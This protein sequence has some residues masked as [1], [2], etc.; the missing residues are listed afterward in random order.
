MGRRALAIRAR[1]NGLGAQARHQRHHS[2]L[3]LGT[4]GPYWTLGTHP[5]DR[6][7]CQS[8][9]AQ[10]DPNFGYREMTA[11]T[12]T[13]GVTR[14]MSEFFRLLSSIGAILPPRLDVLAPR[15]LAPLRHLQEG[16]AGG[17]LDFIKPQP[18][19]KPAA[20]EAAYRPRPCSRTRLFVGWWWCEVAAARGETRVAL[21]NG[22]KLE[23]FCGVITVTLELSGSKFGK[24]HLVA[25]ARPRTSK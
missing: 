9:C 21:H 23:P 12:C 11:C 2:P 8:W 14:S 24:E 6:A 4:C 13:H 7:A 5:S 20:A 3:R 15:H 18:P 1:R 17:F 25:R 16:L 19:S 22:R 10:P